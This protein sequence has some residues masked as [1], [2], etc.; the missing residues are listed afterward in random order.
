MV[1]TQFMRALRVIELQ[2][3]SRSNTF[4]GEAGTKII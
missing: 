3:G 1:E 2:R 4:V